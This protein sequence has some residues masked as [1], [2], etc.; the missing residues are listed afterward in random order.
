M[1]NW[2]PDATS[3]WGPRSVRAPAWSHWKAASCCVVGRS[4]L[5][6]V[7]PAFTRA[8]RFFQWFHQRRRDTKNP[9]GN[10]MLLSLWGTYLEIYRI[11]VRSICAIL[12]QV[13]RLV[14]QSCSTILQKCLKLCFYTAYHLCRY[15]TIIW[16]WKWLNTMLLKLTN[17]F[18][19]L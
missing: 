5:S 7:R 18:C 19:Q 15:E 14:S 12:S 9:N 4:P 17:T 11:D 2:A 10:R 16:K 8:V 3:I 6:P 1:T 13:F